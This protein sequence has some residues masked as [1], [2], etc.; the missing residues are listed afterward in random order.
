M[1]NSCA[2]MAEALPLRDRLFDP[3]SLAGQVAGTPLVVYTVMLFTLAAAYLALWWTARDYRV[4]RGM[5]LYIGLCAVQMIWMYE[6]GAKSNWALVAFT[7]PV[8]VM[9]AGE[10]MRVPDR[11]WTL[12]IWPFSVFVFFAGWF[13][14]FQFLQ[15]L[16]VDVSDIM[17]LVLVIQSVRRGQRR[18]RQI[19]AAFAFFAC[20]RSTL[21]SNFNALTHFSGR[22]EVGGWVWAIIP[23]AI[24][25]LGMATLV[26]YVRDLIEDRREK[27]R[28]SA[29]LE[30]A[31][32]VQQVLI[33]EEIPVVSGFSIEAVYKPFGE[34]GGD[35]FQI[36]PIK[37]G[38]VLVV[39]GDVSGKGMPAAM[40]VSL[41]VG[42]VRTLA[43]YT[44]SPGEILAA[45]N[46][47]MLGRS[48]GGFTTCLVLRA[49]GDGKFV[50]ANAGHIAPYLAGKELPLE[51]GL[52]LGLAAEA[53]YAESTFQL[54]SGQQVTLLTD[55][56][57]EAREKDG[58]LFGFERTAAISRKSAEKVAQAAQAFGQ[59]D[60]ITVLTIARSVAPA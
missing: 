38:G 33:P 27:Q 14:S 16:P 19:A 41:M 34:V 44:Q 48:R 32:T 49:D 23:P 22:V 52:P 6:G 36:L 54:A 29:E 59:D 51:N 12:L 46:H 10:A 50:L 28:M 55:G 58:G 25:L 53:A 21:S 57:V 18:D 1:I 35:F 39:I 9:I 60:D 47:R 24:I 11:R 30:A 2:W 56:V 42:T 20:I 13:P 31:R 3:V 17:I 43:H 8:L 40:T 37:E 15:P 45:M 4:F 26:I 5:S 7:A